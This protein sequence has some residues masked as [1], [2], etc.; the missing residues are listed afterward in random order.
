MA[1]L[2]DVCQKPIHIQKIN[3]RN[4]YQR[5]PLEPFKQVKSY[6]TS[7]LKKMS[8]SVYFEQELPLGDSPEELAEFSGMSTMSV[9]RTIKI[10]IKKGIIKEDAGY[11]EIIDEKGLE[12]LTEL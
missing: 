9:V 4:Y 2:C 12:M 5:C 1:W 6:Y 11:V 8:N 7:E 3:G 10:F